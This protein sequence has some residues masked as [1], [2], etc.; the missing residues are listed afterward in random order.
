MRNPGRIKNKQ[1]RQEV[2]LRYKQEKRRLGHERRA[3][4][5]EEA[6]GSENAAKEE[7]ATL[8]N[9]R[10][11]EE[12]F[13]AEDDVEVLADEA[14]DEFSRQWSG[15]ERPK[16]ML[17]TR[18]KPSGRL[19]HFIADLQQLLPNTFYYP[20]RHFSVGKICRWA[21][22][23]NFSHVVVLMERKKE[24]N[25]LVVSKLPAGPTAFFKVSNA[26]LSTKVPNRGAP[27]SHTPELLLNNFR[28][29]LGRR[30]ARILGSLLPHQP[31]FQ[32]RQVVTMHNQRDFI[33][34][35]QHRYIF[36]ERA[37]A[38]AAAAAAGAAGKKDE[39]AKAQE[40]IKTRLQELGPR[41]TLKLKWIQEGTFDQ[42]YGEYEW[43][44]KRHQM[45]TSRRKFHL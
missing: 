40:S 24:C 41:F 43:I 13:V 22:A 17:T 18:P 36:N 12:T 31:Q 44:H 14:D 28:T 15:E 32:G 1:K 42:M 26:V 23:K 38:A 10:E 29:R 21:A 34:V 4:R 39:K 25:G 30:V 37:D 5:Q 9:R 2:Y 6:A 45:D 20:R 27:T 35:R 8:E 11:E 7:P 16:I 3:A 19:F 33:F